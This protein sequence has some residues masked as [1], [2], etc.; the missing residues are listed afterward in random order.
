MSDKSKTETLTPP[1]G[2]IELPSGGWALLRETS[3]AN[4]ATVQRV[5]RALNLD[6]D[7][8]IMTE[9]CATAITALLEDWQFPGDVKHAFP[10]YANASAMLAQ[11]PADDLLVLEEHVTPWVGR[12]LGLR[13]KMTATGPS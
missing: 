10:T 13:R 12:I 4:G 11:L 8:D 2:A 5:R 1:P 6:G 7:G 3:A 9:A